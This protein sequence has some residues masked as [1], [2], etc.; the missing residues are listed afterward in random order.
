[1]LSLYDS[2]YAYGYRNYMRSPDTST[3][4]VFD[5]THQYSLAS[6]CENCLECPW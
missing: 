1:M 2:K 4:L 6:I 3:E 5:D